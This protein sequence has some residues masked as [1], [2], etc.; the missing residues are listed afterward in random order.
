MRDPH[1]ERLYFQIGSAE[2][3]SYDRPEPLTFD[4]D[5][6]RFECHDGRLVVAPEAHFTDPDDARVVVEPFLRGWEIDSDLDGNIGTIRFKYLR[7]DVVDRDPPPPGASVTIAAKAGSIGISGA[8]ATGHVTR[9]KYPRPPT[10][11]RAS[12]DV[13]QAYNR[14]LA[15][16]HSQEPLLS[17]AYF[18]LTILEAGAGG[19]DRAA[20]LLAV[21][22][23]VLANVGRLSSTRGDPG[24]ARKAAKAGTFQPLTPVETNWLEAAIPRLIRRLG[25]REAGAALEQIRMADLPLLA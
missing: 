23:K 2:H 12:A 16:R 10:S 3:V 24:T 18:V 8:A 14:W 21:D 25:E 17:M 4:N 13:Q 22:E 9:R 1:V 11:F 19:R 7:A 6:G 15:Y 5:L 20:Q